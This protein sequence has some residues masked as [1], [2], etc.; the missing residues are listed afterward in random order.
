M[1]LAWGPTPVPEALEEISELLGSVRDD[2]AAEPF[3]LA[4]HAHLLAEAGDIDAARRRS[5]ACGTSPSDWASGLC[6][7]A[8][9]GQNVGRSRAARGRPRACR[10][11]AATLL[12][13]ASR[14]G[15]RAF[16][17]TLAGNSRTRWST[18]GARRTQRPTR[19]RRATRPARPTSLAGPLGSALARALAEQGNAEDALRLGDEAVALSET[20]EWPNV[21]ADALLDRARVVQWIASSP[22][23]DVRVDLSEPERSTSRRRTRP[24]ARKPASSRLVRSRRGKQRLKKESNDDRRASAPATILRIR[25]TAPAHLNAS[26]NRRFRNPKREAD[27]QSACRHLSVASRGLP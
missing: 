26:D 25:R 3:V 27:Q 4:G 9:W 14:G 22:E 24:D 10:A 13:R 11:G 2:P 8:S 18:W 20:T 19:L 15:H 1:N 12:P 7:G 21:I 17:S 16:S 6:S 5:T 23:R